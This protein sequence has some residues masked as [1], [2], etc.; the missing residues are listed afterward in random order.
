MAA[1]S[2]RGGAVL[3]RE[4]TEEESSMA[5][6]KFG[7]ERGTSEVRRLAEDGR[8]ARGPCYTRMAR[9]IAM[10]G[11]TRLRARFTERCRL[12]L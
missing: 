6:G 1:S 9:N 10:R 7:C 8:T 4:V 2:V 3:G 5:A 11:A 12:F